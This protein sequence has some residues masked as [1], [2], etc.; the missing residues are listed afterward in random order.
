MKFHKIY[1]YFQHH[2][3][4][5]DA[6]YTR[7][8][9][10]GEGEIINMVCLNLEKVRFIKLRKVYI[11]RSG[12]NRSLFLGSIEFSS[13]FRRISIANVIFFIVL[14]FFWISILRMMSADWRGKLYIPICSRLP[15]FCSSGISRAGPDNCWTYL[16]LQGNDSSIDSTCA[17]TARWAL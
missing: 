17:L 2:S 3:Q 7:C 10:N 4:P 8:C 5:F 15:Q 14:V 1:S 6:V 16:S 11:Q 12:L 9:L 13:F